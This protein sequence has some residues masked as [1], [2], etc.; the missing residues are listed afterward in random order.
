MVSYEKIF[1]QIILNYQKHKKLLFVDHSVGSTRWK[2]NNEILGSASKIMKL[3]IECK[4]VFFRIY[5]R[6]T[7]L[8][9]IRRI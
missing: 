4:N 7:V 5:E 1:I 2:M 8:I 6:L 9:V 3:M